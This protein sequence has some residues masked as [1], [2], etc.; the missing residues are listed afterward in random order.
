MDQKV[1]DFPP[2]SLVRP[3]GKCPV[4]CFRRGPAPSDLAHPFCFCSVWGDPG[5]FIE[6]PF[7]L[8]GSLS[9][10]P[11]FRSM[12]QTMEATDR[13]TFNLPLSLGFLTTVLQEMFAIPKLKCGSLGEMTLETPWIF[14]K[15]L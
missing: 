1:G 14:Q 2:P 12:S 15:Y 6:W 11:Q 3:P 13:F 4:P 10:S 7:D 5:A 8:D 9:L